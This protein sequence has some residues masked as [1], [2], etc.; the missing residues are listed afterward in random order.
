[1]TVLSNSERLLV[2]FHRRMCK[3][4][5]AIKRLARALLLYAIAGAMVGVGVFLLIGGM[6]LALMG[7]AIGIGLIPMVVV[8]IIGGL[9]VKGL[10]SSIRNK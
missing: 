1:M 5:R 4:G 9:A 3:V 7:T 6:G 10:V 8:G 2:V